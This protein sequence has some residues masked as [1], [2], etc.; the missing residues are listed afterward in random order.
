VGQTDTGKNIANIA[1]HCRS[2]FLYTEKTGFIKFM[3]QMH[4][5]PFN[6]VMGGGERIVHHHLVIGHIDPGLPPLIPNQKHGLRQVKRG[7]TGIKRHGNNGI[8]HGNMFVAHTGAF[9]PEHHT[10]FF[11]LANIGTHFRGKPPRGKN[12]F[13]SIT[14]TCSCHINTVQ[15]GQRVFFAF[16]HPGIVDHDI[17]A[18][19]IGS[20]PFIGPAIARAHQPQIHQPAIQHCPRR[21][22]NIIAKL[23]FN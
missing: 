7:K 11:A 13:N 9:R 21:L 2:L 17:R 3:L 15:I 12:R 22:A 8:R 14:G 20:C 10:N 16:K 19:R 4:K 5:H 23:R 18:G 6:L 1:F